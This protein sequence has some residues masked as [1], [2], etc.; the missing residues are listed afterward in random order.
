MVNLG[1]M[2]KTS[3]LFSPQK[4]FIHQGCIGPI[5]MQEVMH[6][7]PAPRKLVHLCELQ[8]VFLK[9]KK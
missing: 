6:G 1:C 5:V 3:A 8:F 7:V 2:G 9:S 4:P